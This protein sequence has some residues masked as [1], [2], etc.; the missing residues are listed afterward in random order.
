SGR[1]GVR[2]LVIGGGICGLSTALALHAAGIDVRV[3]ESV[4]KMGA[5]G[6]GINIQPNAVRE[7]IE[8]G[9]GEA[10]EEGA[11]A[12][13][14]LAFYSKHGQRIWS[15]PR[16]LAAG[17]RW[18]QYSIHRGTLQMILYDA[19]RARIGEH[20]LFLGHTL[21]SFSQDAGGVTANFADRAGGTK[22]EA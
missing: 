20:N 21:E 14:E 16:G 10:L 1:S 15:E 8:L 17:Y 12:T 6:V 19:V 11:G 5:V 7:L 9:L 4:P 2:V 13:R 22:L 18:P 3:Y